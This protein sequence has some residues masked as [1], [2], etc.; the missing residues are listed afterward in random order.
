MGGYLRS[1]GLPVS[2]YRLRGILPSIAPLSHS[3]RQNEGIER[4]NPRVY[5]ARYF[6]H[7]VHI[8]QNEKLA[9]FGITYV[10]ARDGY[11]GKIVGSSIM[12]VKNNLIIYEEVYSQMTLEYGLFDKLR[13][14]HGREFYLMLYIH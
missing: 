4:A 6:G 9:M 5:V 3:Q 14:D 7:K 11:S 1:K 12:A 2:E 13:V 8:D 10:L